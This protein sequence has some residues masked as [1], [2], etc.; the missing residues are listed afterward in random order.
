VSSS[1]TPRYCSTSY[2]WTCFFQVSHHF[3]LSQAISYSCIVLHPL[4]CMFHDTCSYINY[5]NSVHTKSWPLYGRHTHA[6]YIYIYIYIL[7]IASFP[8]PLDPQDDPTTILRRRGITITIITMI[9]YWDV[10]VV[11]IYNLMSPCNTRFL[12]GA[13]FYQRYSHWSVF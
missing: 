4:H 11:R 2:A 5:F 1:K 12:R 13:D 7:N 3:V 6:H 10:R 8:G 9:I